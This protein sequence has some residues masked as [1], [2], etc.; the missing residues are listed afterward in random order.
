MTEYVFLYCNGESRIFFL[1]ILKKYELELKPQRVDI[2]V[3]LIF[4]VRR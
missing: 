1:K 3:M 2:S 4:V